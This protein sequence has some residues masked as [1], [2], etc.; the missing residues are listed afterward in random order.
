MMGDYMEPNITPMQ[1]NVD[2]G[3]LRIRVASQ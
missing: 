1:D 2:E 3:Q